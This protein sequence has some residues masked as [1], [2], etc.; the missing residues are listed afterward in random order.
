[1]IRTLDG[2]SCSDTV[3]VVEDTVAG[4]THI[5]YAIDQDIDN[6]FQPPT[7]T[8]KEEHDG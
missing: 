4:G 5:T 8:D 2:C 6:L 3:L 1:M 7:T